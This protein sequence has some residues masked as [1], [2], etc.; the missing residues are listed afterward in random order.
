[1][2][3]AELAVRMVALKELLAGCDVA[4]L[5]SCWRLAAVGSDWWKLNVYIVRKYSLQVEQE[6]ALY[7]GGGSRS[8]VEARVRRRASSSFATL[9]KASPCLQTL[10]TPV[11]HTDIIHSLC[12]VRTSPHS[13][14][15][16]HR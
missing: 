5:V 3:P 1:M 8:E 11:T 6:P 4:L 14:F 12:F 16:Y 15:M 13:Y 10:I 9:S 7:L 2:P